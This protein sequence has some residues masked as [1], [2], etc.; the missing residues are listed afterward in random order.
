[1]KYASIT[2]CSS[3]CVMGKSLKLAPLNLLSPLAASPPHVSENDEHGRF[4]G[5]CQLPLI[6]LAQWW[7]SVYQFRRSAEKKPP[8]MAIS[9]EVI[10]F[11][12]LNVFDISG[13]DAFEIVAK[14]KSA[15]LG[16]T[17][18]FHRLR[19][20]HAGSRAERRARSARSENLNLTQSRWRA[21]HDHAVASI[22]RN[23]I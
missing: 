20:A 13:G 23:A 11:H 1:M 3:L 21:C 7:A 17:S 22:R 16:P 6:F 5:G 14:N 9:G 8:S 2:S 15:T 12:Q 18:R 10:R 19:L 4:R